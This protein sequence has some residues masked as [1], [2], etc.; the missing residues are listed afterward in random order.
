MAYQFR[1]VYMSSGDLAV[2]ATGDLKLSTPKED[3]EQMIEFRLRTNAL[4]FVPSPYIGADLRRFVGNP[5]TERT[6]HYITEAI[7]RCLTQDNFMKPTELA[8]E[9]VPISYSSVMA[10]IFIKKHVVDATTDVF[11]RTPPLVLSYTIGLDTNTIQ[12]A[13]GT[14]E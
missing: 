6:G 5:N 9:V 3:L 10:V 4:E 7:I 8:V 11:S 14:V 1:D 2:D 13:T 12:R